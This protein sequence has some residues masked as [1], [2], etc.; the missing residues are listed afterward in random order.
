MHVASKPTLRCD[1][2]KIIIQ[3][4]VRSPMIPC[5]SNV[6]SVCPVQLMA[7]GVHGQAQW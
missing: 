4:I 3:V 6:M 7:L 5:R 2:M 1:L